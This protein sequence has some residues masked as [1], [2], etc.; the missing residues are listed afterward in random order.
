MISKLCAMC[1]AE[2]PKITFNS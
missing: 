2:K 1:I